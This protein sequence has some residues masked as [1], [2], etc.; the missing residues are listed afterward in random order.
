MIER[1]QST[2]NSLISAASAHGDRHGNDTHI[3]TLESLVI[4]AC[5]VMTDEQWSAFLNADVCTELLQLSAQK[6]L[7]DP[8][9]GFVDTEQNWLKKMP[10]WEGDQQERFDSLVAVEKDEDGQWVEVE[11]SCSLR[12]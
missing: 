4:A 3:E 11:P 5:S 12:P 7:M 1:N 8:D 2:L 6:Y 10:T 9:V